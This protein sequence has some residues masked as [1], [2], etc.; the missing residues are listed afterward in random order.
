MT[1]QDFWKHANELK[2]CLADQKTTVSRRRFP[3]DEDP[4]DTDMFRTDEIKLLQS[5]TF[6]VM[7][8]KTQVFT[9]PKSPLIRTRLSHVLE[10]VA[11]AVKV[12]DLLGLNTDLVRAAALGHDIGHVPF[13]H[14]GEHWMAQAMDKPNFCHEV[15][16]VV[17]A[18]KIERKGSGLNL[19]WHTLDAMM[20][21]SGSK[22]DNSMSAEA[23]VLRYADKIAYL[24]HDINDVLN[25][26]SYLAKPE[27][28]ELF[29][30]FGANQRQRTDTAIAA[31]IIESCEC[32]K[33]CFEHSEWAKKFA[34]LRKLMYEIYPHVTRQDLD[35]TLRPIHS[36]LCE[37]N[38]ADPFLLMALMT[39]TDVLTMMNEKN[40]DFQGFRRTGVA[41]IMPYLKDIGCIDL[42]DPDL[43]W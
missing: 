31:L 42:C 4:L 8:S 39:D 34:Q 9:F 23:W 35:S 43:N 22:S 24:F 20:R 25:R 11:C 7:A 16:G 28:T 6:R 2:G 5:K 19:T 10:V 40:P 38:L 13:G 12:A 27:L 3:Q 41:E 26:M 36:F 18:Q 1:I 21:H 14:P 15:M 33:V 32:G 17:T 29:I 37:L 30:S